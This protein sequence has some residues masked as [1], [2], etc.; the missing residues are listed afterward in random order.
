MYFAIECFRESNNTENKFTAINKSFTLPLNEMSSDQT[1]S[2]HYQLSSSTSDPVQDKQETIATIDNNIPSRYYHMR[3]LLL[4][5]NK[6]V[7]YIKAKYIL[8]Y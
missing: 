6:Y 2:N 3:Q 7:N 1:A 5:E 4:N 8:Y